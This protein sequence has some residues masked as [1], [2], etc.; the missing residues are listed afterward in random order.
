MCGWM[1]ASD[2]SCGAAGCHTARR[3][4]LCA[5]HRRRSKHT[6]PCR[7]A[8]WHPCHTGLKGVAGVTCDARLAASRPSRGTRTGS[9][10]DSCRLHEGRCRGARGAPGGRESPD[11]RLNFHLVAACWAI[12]TMVKPGL[13]PG[14][15]EGRV[16]GRVV[17]TPIVRSVREKRA[18][19][20]A[21]GLQGRGALTIVLPPCCMGASVAAR[22]RKGADHA[23]T[24]VKRRGRVF[25]SERIHASPRRSPRRR[26]VG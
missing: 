3:R 20:A 15:V 10:P 5:I 22:E 16:A 21:G 19:S 24:G 13:C 23:C 17:G 11:A 18:S 2:V 8:V 12:E 4:L 25:R 14:L 6:A 7:D 26:E 1:E 9:Y